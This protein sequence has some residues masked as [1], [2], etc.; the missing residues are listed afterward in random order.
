MARS[1]QT[2]LHMGLGEFLLRA[3]TNIFSVAAILIVIWLAHMYF[4]DPVARAQVSGQTSQSLTPL[5]PA[6][7]QAENGSMDASSAGIVRGT[8]IHTLVPARARQEII[9]YTVQAGDTVSG[10]AD[11]Y[12]LQPKTVFAANYELL[13]DDPESLRPGQELKILPLDG[14]YWEC[15]F[16]L[17]FDQWVAAGHWGD[18]KPE[19]ILNYPGNHL[20]P[21]AIADPANPNIKDGTFLIIPGGQY[22]YH[23]QGGIPVGLSRTNPPT[24]QV[25]GSG[26]CTKDQITGT[27]VGTGG[28]LDF[29]TDRQ[30][31]SGYDFSTKTN[32]LGVDLAANLGDNIYA[33]DSGV[34]VYA[35]A[36][37]YG[38]GN[39]IMIDHG[40]LQT[41]YAH[42][43][44][45]FV[46]CGDNVSRHQT[47]GAA[48]MTGHAS[49][50]HLHFEVRTATEVVNPRDWLPPFASAPS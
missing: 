22:T 28:L 19:D 30:Y 47:I 37:S 13:G 40:T 33:A 16:G 44:Q 49:G 18:V 11:R 1:F 2:L 29:P 6:P 5:P 35:G 7:L 34:V 36:N 23:K 27:A 12:G 24:A 42:L 17:P 48:G 39:M 43:S 14:I 41:L 25:G 32:H 50:P 4:R 38:Y 31:L 45:I 26:Y 46:N 15:C 10:I 21:A 20:D 9:S 8:N 3:A